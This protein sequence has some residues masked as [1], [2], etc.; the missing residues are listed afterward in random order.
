VR[1]FEA[2]LRW[3]AEVRIVFPTDIRATADPSSG[4]REGKTPDGT[5]P[6]VP[7]TIDSDPT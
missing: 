7:I 6:P 1:C 3:G 4:R 2:V 5:P